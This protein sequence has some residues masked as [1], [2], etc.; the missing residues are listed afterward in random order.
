MLAG[1]SE[2]GIIAPIAAVKDPRIHAIA[3][4]AGSSY[5][6]RHILNYQVGNQVK[7]LLAAPAG[8]ATRAA[9]RARGLEGPA[10][11]Q[12]M[13]DSIVNAMITSN[14]W[15]K[16]FADTDPK[17]MLRQVRQ[18][19]LVLQGDTDWQVTPEQADTIVATLRAAGNTRVTMQRFP[20]TNHLLVPDPVG[21]PTGYG[22]LK[23]VRVRKEVLGALAD[24]VERIAR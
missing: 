12:F 17:V 6:G 15:T 21:S 2:G 1:H 10:L 5:D 20:A 3:L 19:V 9:G 24:W 13:T 18:P 4:L 8:E 16:Y 14:A 23:D 22:A 11:Q 7:A